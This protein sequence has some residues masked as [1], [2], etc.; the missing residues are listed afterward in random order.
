MAI[1]KRET[2][3][4]QQK[5]ELKCSEPF[6]SIYKL[7]P[8]LDQSGILRVGGR[9]ENA[10]IDYEAKHQTLLPYNHH[11]SRLIIMAHHELVG[12]FGT[13]YVLASLRQ[14]YWIVK[15]RPMVCKVIGR[16]LICRRYNVCRGQ[17]LI[18]DLPS[19][20]LTP[21]NPPFTHVGIDFLGPLYVKRGRSILK[22]YG[23]LFTCLT[24]QATHIEVTESLDTD[25]FI[26]A[27]RRFISRRGCPRIIRSDN[28]TNLSE[29][30]KEIR[31]AI[32]TWNHQKIEKYLQQKD[33]QWKF[34][35]P[36]ASHM[37]GVWE[38]VIWS[39]RK[40]IRCLTK[41]QLVSGEAL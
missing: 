21:D 37:G 4:R 41:E 18:A 24:M 29:G 25:S 16:C 5:S 40:V 38:R 3:A 17:Q 26:N 20:R 15:G 12:H 6:G 13:E 39:V 30:E 14:K 1:L 22:H 35:P 7:R 23:C 8:W 32:N 31:D 28:G 27:L 9:L 19:D 11:V 2:P 10:Q 34:N 36:G 33:I